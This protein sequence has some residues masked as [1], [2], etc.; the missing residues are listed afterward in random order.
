MTWHIEF[1]G[2]GVKGKI[3]AH[4]T[5]DEQHR[6][7]R[8]ALLD[9]V[10]RSGA[11][12]KAGARIPESPAL[13]STNL[14]ESKGKTTRSCAFFSTWPKIWGL[15]VGHMR[16]G[17]REMENPPPGL[18]PGFTSS[19]H[20]LTRRLR[21]QSLRGGRELTMT[22][23]T[24]SNAARVCVPRRLRRGGRRGWNAGP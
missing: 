13:F 12:G 4:R 5:R 11:R 22:T 17:L 19:R 9:S 2:P 16:S 23:L 24:A 20:D 18:S 6:R 8:P 21:R 14:A 10:I 1:R 3:S 15:R 7:V